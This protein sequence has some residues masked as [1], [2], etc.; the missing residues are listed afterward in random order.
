MQKVELLVQLTQWLGSK[1]KPSELPAGHIATAFV[2]L[3]D[4]YEGGNPW[5]K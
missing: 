3:Q 1:R 5:L 2:D 4:F